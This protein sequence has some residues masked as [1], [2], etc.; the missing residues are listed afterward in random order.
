VYNSFK[1]WHLLSFNELH[2]P[3]LTLFNNGESKG[4]VTDKKAYT[5]ITTAVQLSENMASAC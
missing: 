3:Q 2:Y 1:F 4:S 5:T